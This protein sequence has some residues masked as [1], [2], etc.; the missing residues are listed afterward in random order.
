MA[1][2]PQRHRARWRHEVASFGYAIQGIREALLSEPHLRFH[3]L[4][5]AVVVAL[6]AWLH[7]SRHD[8]ALLALA[9]GAVWAAELMNTAI[10]T[11]IDLVS[12]D[13]HPLAGRA[14][15][16]AAGA[17]LLMALAAGVVGL[18]VFGPP[19]WDKA[20]ALNGHP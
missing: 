17:V 8:W 20:V 18:L 1:K 11:I 15:D 4:A 3:A 16:V 10:E 12:P 2:A 9:V 5:T 7:V 19:L 13:F 14:K 6:G